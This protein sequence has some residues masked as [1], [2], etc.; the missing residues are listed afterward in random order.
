[1]AWGSL[2]RPPPGV[3]GE[4]C[5]LTVDGVEEWICVAENLEPAGSEVH[6]QQYPAEEG[7]EV[8]PKAIA[9]KVSSL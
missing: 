9:P 7:R 6:G 3:V 8:A 5:P 4:E 1:M 2:R